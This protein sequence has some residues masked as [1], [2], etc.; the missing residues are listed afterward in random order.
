MHPIVRTSLYVATG[1]VVVGGGLLTIPTAPIL[2]VAGIAA[3]TIVLVK[4]VKGKV[5]KNN[6][7]HSQSKVDPSKNLNK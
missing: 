3:G 4:C 6:A 2:A 5:S 1:G 7:S